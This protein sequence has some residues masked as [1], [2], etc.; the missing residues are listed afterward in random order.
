MIKYGKGLATKNLQDYGYPVFGGNGIIGRY[1][2]YL[3]KEPQILISCRGAASGNILESLPYS[4]VTSNSLVVE[5]ADRKYYEIIKRFLMLHPLHSYATGSAQPQITID[6]LK[7]V[8]VPYPEMAEL[9]KITPLF[10]SFAQ[11]TLQIHTENERLADIR[12]ALLPK[13]M[14][15][16]IDVSKVDI[17]DPSCLDK[18]LFSL[19]S[20]AC[21]GRFFDLRPFAQ[22]YVGCGGATMTGDTSICRRLFGV[23]QPQASAKIYTRQSTTSQNLCDGWAKHRQNAY[24]S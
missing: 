19:I 13:L 14:N 20:D 12:D 3:Y 11:K 21:T 9:N 18:S 2:D 7:N 22:I 15:G 10:E 17:S 24:I 16:E 23:L 8:S 5:L 6:N 4:Y 1:F